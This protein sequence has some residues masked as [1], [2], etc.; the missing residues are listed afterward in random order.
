MGEVR[1]FL[2]C[3]IIYKIITYISCSQPD[4]IFLFLS[5]R[6]QQRISKRERVLEGRSNLSHEVHCPLFPDV[7]QEYWWVYI[8]DRK[9]Q[10]LLTTPIHVTSLAQFEEIQLRF[11]APRWPGLYT[12]TVCLRSDSYLG[13]DQAQDIK[14]S[15]LKIVKIQVTQQKILFFIIYI[16]NDMMVLCSWT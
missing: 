14:V 11:T 7:K 15:Y 1:I 9:S 10:T 5:N 12:F 8:C 2:F 6:F 4:L 3:Y 13:F 16:C